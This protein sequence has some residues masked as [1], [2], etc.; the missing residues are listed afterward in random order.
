MNYVR[1]MILT[2]V[3]ETL[4]NIQK[5][6]KLIGQHNSEAVEYVPKHTYTLRVNEFGDWTQDEFSNMN[7]GT[8]ISPPTCNWYYRS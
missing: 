3:A 7:L 1:N 8:V 6:V 5:N 2:G 4:R